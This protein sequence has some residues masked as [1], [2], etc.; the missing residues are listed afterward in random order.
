MTVPF[1]K[2]LTA[3]VLFAALLFVPYLIRLSESANRDAE[4][5]AN[6]DASIERYGFYLENR[7]EDLG[8]QFTHQRSDLD[9]Q[10]DHIEAQIASVGASVSV[11]DLNQDGREDIYLT[12]SAI[13]QP[14][15]LFVQQSDGRFVDNASSF[16]LADVNTEELGVSMGSIWGDM[17]NDGDEDLFL[18]RW[19]TPTVYENTG[20]ESFFRMVPNSG[21]PDHV[22][23]NTAVWVDVNLDGFLDLFLGGYYHED[24]N[25]FDVTS[26]RLMPDSYEYA[27]NGGLNYLFLGRGDG[28]F[29]DVSMEYGIQV[30]RR[31]TLAAT[32]ADLN[33]DGYPDLILA[34]DYGVDQIF[35]NEE[36]RQ[37]RESG[38]A[39]GIGFAPKSGMSASV[40]DLYGTGE[41]SI[42]VS[43]ISEP[44]VLMQG[45]N[46]WVAT[47][48]RAG[49][50]T[51][52]NIANSVGVERGEWGYGGTLT[53]LN[54]DGYPD[55]YLANGY[56][57]DE[58][59]TDYWYDYAKVV[60]GHKEIIIDAKNWPA[61]NG[62]TFSGYQ[63]N[64]IWLN[65][66]SGKFREVGA[67]VGG[68]EV[69]DSRA[70]AMI[71]LNN[72]G[73]QDLIVANQHQPVLVYQNYLDAT[74]NWIG[75]RLEGS[76]SN[77][78]AIGAEVLLYWDDRI[79][80]QM[81]HGGTAFSSQSQRAL[82]F[83]LHDTQTVE[84]AEIRWPSGVV[85][86]LKEP[87][88]GTYHTVLEPNTSN[89]SRLLDVTAPTDETTTSSYKT[90]TSSD[91]TT[92]SHEDHTPDESTTS[93]PTTT[94]I[95][96]TPS[97]L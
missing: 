3:A 53:D 69:T 71:D 37:F 32:A 44:G 8:I 28:T 22:N 86:L 47:G 70:V 55:L 88:T 67:A 11:T 83:G 24:V 95:L 13:G 64:K 14:N 20:G 79:S 75:F 78:S 81:I 12:S 68:T 45:N 27:T 52:Q 18:Y 46:L 5:A 56:I 61:M 7:A 89:G 82:L 29:E 1:W 49:V 51:F 26:T 80:R 23:A 93:D 57:S 74:R 33:D 54:N 72:D 38:E 34:N 39:M 2:K 48:D 16:G 66:G 92:G 35:L 43:N 59:G 21:L 63:R 84:R 94:S 87:E 19:G 30:D 17:D 60:G 96:P 50:P 73:S 9:P 91:K 31:W 41:Y 65:S 4:T 25:L 42:Y 85:Q 90:T 58:P 76:Q 62:R 77:R 6:R 40:A 10:L 97:N 15:A 36:G